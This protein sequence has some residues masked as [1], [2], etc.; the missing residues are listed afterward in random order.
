M[1][2]L[3]ILLTLTVICLHLPQLCHTQEDNDFAEFEDFDADDFD[4]EVVSENSQQQKQQQDKND[5]FTEL[6][7]DDDDD[8]GVVEDEESEFEH[9]QDEEEFEGFSNGAGDLPSDIPTTND[10]KKTEPK[11]VMAKVPMNFRTHRDSYWMEMIMLA[12]LLAYFT[13]YFL[14]RN[15]NSKLANL[16][17]A[18][19][20][21]LLEEN[22]AM[23]G[24]DSSKKDADSPAGFMKESESLYTLWCSGR[25]CCEG[26][27]VELKM[28][29]RQD[30]VAILS[31]MM[32]P[33]LDQIQIKVEISKDIMDPFVF[34]VAAKKTA[35]KLFKELSDLV[36]NFEYI[37]MTKD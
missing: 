32:R 6:E 25:T 7:V 1:K 22:F 15:K 30:L 10:P 31:G 19:H 5:D 24:D 27:L 11:L 33:T 16:W 2:F 3:L 21:T 34:C 12:G 36:S 8:D 35:S 23:I 18:T 20:R 9:F 13:N 4:S 29:K 14:G 37:R 26:M 17:L 28:I